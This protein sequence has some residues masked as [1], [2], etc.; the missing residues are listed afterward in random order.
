MNVSSGANVAINQALNRTGFGID[1]APDPA[2]EAASEA[3]RSDEVAIELAE[4]VSSLDT[5]E[6]VLSDEE[7]AIRKDAAAEDEM[8]ADP[9]VVDEDLRELS[10]DSLGA[11][12]DVGALLDR[13]VE[14]VAR[15]AVREDVG[16]HSVDLRH[17]TRRPC[18][19]CR[20]DEDTH[21]SRSWFGHLGSSSTSSGEETVGWVCLWCESVVEE[22]REGVARVVSTP[23]GSPTVDPD[24]SDLWADV[25]RGEGVETDGGRDADRGLYGK[26][27]VRKDGD[28]VDDCFVLEPSSDP[29]AREALRAYAESTENE[30]LADDLR[31]WVSEAAE[32]R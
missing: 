18:P 12:D 15:E 14:Q 10:S 22:T 6:G 4:A 7:R 1:G 21:G 28:R 3:V 9:D 13:R 25:D 16:G 32:G 19:V 2:R 26:Y 5:V 11:L 27:D 8:L 29:A 20:E 23:E 24:V 31:E 17:V 30:A